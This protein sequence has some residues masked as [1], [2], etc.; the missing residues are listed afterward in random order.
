MKQPSQLETICAET[1][2]AILDSIQWLQDNEEALNQDTEKLQRRLKLKAFNAKKLMR[3][4]QRKPG[5]GVFGVSQAGKS[6]LVST[7]ARKDTN[8]LMAVF[9]DIDINF[10]ES[11]NPEGGKESTGVVTRFTVDPPENYHAD[12]P[13]CIDLLS[14]T[15]II[16]ILSNSYVFDLRHDNDK[17]EAHDPDEL[18]QTL[19]EIEAS[20]AKDPISPL[21]EEDLIDLAQYC[22][23]K[24]GNRNSN[25]RMDALN[26]IDYWNRAAK[27]GPYL[28]D[29][30]LQRL[31]GLL[32]EDLQAI[33]KIFSQLLDSLNQLEH[34]QTAFC[35]LEG[36]C[37]LDSSGRYSRR[38]DGSIVDVETLLHRG[39]G[40]KESH[41][42][43]VIV[44]TDK[45]AMTHLPRNVLTAL[46]A[47]LVITMK[48]KPAPF[49]DHTDLLD[50]PGAR[51]RE[52]QVKD[53][54]YLDKSDTRA[55]LF[56][57]G[58]VAYLFERYCDNKDLTSLLLC[59]GFENMEVV[60]LPEMV[61]DWISATHGASPEKRAELTDTSLFLVMTKFDA[62]AFKQAAGDGDLVNR[63]T[64]RIK[65]SLIQPYSK[66]PNDWPNHWQG[67]GRVFNHCFC[68]RNPAFRQ[69]GIFEYENNNSINEIGIRADKHDFINELKCSFIESDSMQKHVYDVNKVWDSL[70]TLNDG[71]I[72]ILRSRLETTC[73]SDIKDTQIKRLISEIR[74]DVKSLIEPFYVTGDLDNALKKKLGLAKRI[75]DALKKRTK[76][77]FPELISTLQI[78][79]DALYEIYTRVKN[80]PQDTVEY[81]PDIE[82]ADEGAPDDEDIFDDLFDDE[83][84]PD[85]GDTYK[86][87]FDDSNS[88]TSSIDR[89]PVHHIPND[90]AARYIDAVES[91]WKAY[92]AN[93]NDEVLDYFRIEKQ[94]VQN[95]S[96]ELSVGM[97]REQVLKNIAAQVREVRKHREVDAEA[98]DWKTIAPVFYLFN[99][100]INWLGMRGDSGHKGTEVDL[101]GI[102]RKNRV[103]T[104]FACPDTP[105]EYPELSE[106]APKL[107]E[108]YLSDWRVAFSKVIYDNV[109]YE[110]DIKVNVDAGMNQQLGQIIE[111]LNETS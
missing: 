103:Y 20:A 52:T 16:K 99:E 59:S 18:N 67:V 11:I 84:D 34:P 51:S 33:S 109:P 80:A 61:Y 49:F 102:S 75:S 2:Q 92:L 15:D 24:L 72:S 21:S 96:H 108:K 106:K 23:H 107:G 38:L 105:R 110:L 100:Y 97:Q 101:K 28:S 3:A 32:W 62:T 83:D 56:L 35:S 4:T 87:L 39:I 12:Y 94:L 45:G 82:S 43:N 30:N 68:V 55:R 10:I 71:G 25:H 26:S 47:E 5:I 81:T 70:M 78:D 9:G 64:S 53:P 36:L 111:K 44:R 46:I 65:T 73:K 89:T 76:E 50:F 8:P 95:I 17:K 7:L 37:Q 98:Q 22:Q 1:R 41:G 88:E 54:T 85:E 91:H 63:W 40:E 6:Y 86:N 42:D 58:K 57:R 31:F 48:E 19:K 29:S 69:D 66:T 74:T 13:V 104:V 27:V 93:L 60:S 77:R 14:L 90:F 79:E